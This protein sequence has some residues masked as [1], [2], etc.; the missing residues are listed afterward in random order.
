[1]TGEHTYMVSNVFF[2]LKKFFFLITVTKPTEK[3]R[4]RTRKGPIDWQKK[5][6]DPRRT[7]PVK[8]AYDTRNAEH[9]LFF[10][11][12][13]R[14]VK[15]ERK[16]R[17]TRT[18]GRISFGSLRARSLSMR[19]SR[20]ARRII[21]QVARNDTIVM[22]V[23]GAASRS[24]SVRSIRSVPVFHVCIQQAAKRLGTALM[25]V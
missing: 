11:R 14:L 2:K 12:T 15:S 17:R 25:F 9:M 6:K 5:K 23:C 8:H 3:P 20:G 10:I 7:R 19:I 22:L 1:M 13:C 18:S 4:P 16:A 24:A 21:R